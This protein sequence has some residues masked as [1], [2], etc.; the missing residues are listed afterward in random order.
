MTKWILMMF[1]V[2]GWIWYAIALNSS[3]TPI[4]KQIDVKTMSIQEPD[5][6]VKKWEVCTWTCKNYSSSSSSSSSSWWSS[7]YGGK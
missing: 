6:I 7:S 2:Y 1:L 5:Y 3:Y 4:S